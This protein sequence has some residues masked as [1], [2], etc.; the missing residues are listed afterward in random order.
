MATQKTSLICNNFA[1]IRRVNARFS[2]Q[3]ISCSDCQNVELFDTGINSGVGIR[4]TK[5]NQSLY[6]DFATGESVV[7]IFS[8]NQSSTEYCFVHTETSEAGK[9]YLY[10]GGNMINKYTLSD[11]TGK[12]CGT[13]FTQGWK[14]LFLFSNGDEILKVDLSSSPDTVLLS[15]T[16]VEDNDISGMGF[17]V[18]DSRLWIFKDNRLWYSFKGDC[19]DFSTTD[20]SLTTSAGY[21]EFSKDITA[22]YPYLGSL[23]V[24]HKDSSC[25]VTVDSSGAFSVSE[26]SPG[27]CA[28]YDAL[29]FHGTDLYFYDD[30]KKGVFS[31]QQIVN[32]DKTLGN[33]IAIDV[34]KELINIDIYEFDKLKALSV[35][36]SDR[37][38]VWFLVPQKNETNSTILIYDYIHKEWV[39]RVEPSINCLRIIENSIYSGGEKLYQEYVNESFDGEVLKC[40]YYATPIN[41]GVDNTLKILYFPPRITLDSSYYNDFFIKYIKNYDYLKKTKIK[42]VTNKSL[43]NVLYYDSG[44]CWDSGLCY[45]PTDTTTISKLPSATF[46]TLEMRFYTDETKQDFC[47]RNIEF[48]KI[49]VKQ[50]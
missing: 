2:S 41:L 16:D 15:L 36:L 28:G 11:A 48:S 30:T 50:I 23:A 34:Q 47:I 21:I 32:G 10:Y 27:G 35:V 7:N 1:G 44:Q 20:P 3:L 33:N 49:K 37:N 43:K 40:Y 38:E 22:I 31:F 26:E 25:L 14:D 29:V 9:L 4:T 39:K 17:K 12:S 8:S 45:M 5:G 13:D 6:D 46:K 18:F 42:R 24:F 19:T